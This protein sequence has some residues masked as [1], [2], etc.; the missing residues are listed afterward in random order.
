M[1][2]DSRRSKTNRRKAKWYATAHYN[3]LKK[4]R[5]EWWENIHPPVETTLVGSLGL[6]AKLPMGFDGRWSAR[7]RANG[8][9]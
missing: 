9:L 4:E 8:H 6:V 3:E 1:G 2:Q 7:Q 5:K